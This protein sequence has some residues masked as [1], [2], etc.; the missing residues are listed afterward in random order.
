MKAP[1]PLFPPFMA[2]PEHESEGSRFFRCR[3][4]KEDS[5]DHWTP[6]LPF[7]LETSADGYVIPFG[8]SLAGRWS[9]FSL[10]SCFFPQLALTWRGEVFFFS[11]RLVANPQTFS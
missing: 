5:K 1:F 3:M 6:P 2:M 11:S 9:F 8:T 7:L 4:R 10:R